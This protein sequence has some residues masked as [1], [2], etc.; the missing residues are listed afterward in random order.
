MEQTEIEESKLYCCEDCI[1]TSD[2]DCFDKITKRYNGNMLHSAYCGI[3]YSKNRHDEWLYTCI[4]DSCD[5]EYKIS[6]ESKESKE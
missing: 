3:C 6:K 2:G 1:V 5:R 4:C